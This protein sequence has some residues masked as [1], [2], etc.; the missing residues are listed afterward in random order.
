ML[1]TPGYLAPEQAAPTAP[2]TARSDLYG[3]GA[4]LFEALTGRPPFAGLNAASL[5]RQALSEDAELVGRVRANVPRSLERLL[6]SLLSRDPSGRPLN[7]R[8]VE[9]AAG[10]GRRYPSAVRREPAGCG[11]S[12]RA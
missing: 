3:L 1:G 11:A 4:T 8:L 12:T 7:T 2:A 5:L 9:R 10:R 6:Q